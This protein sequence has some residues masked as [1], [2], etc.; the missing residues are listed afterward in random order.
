[1]RRNV[2]DFASDVRRYV[3]V[4]LLTIS[5]LDLCKVAALTYWYGLNQI[6]TVR[7]LFSSWKQAGGR[8][9]GEAIALTRETAESLETH[10]HLGH[11]SPDSFS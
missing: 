10:S 9:L 3:E 2:Y 8:S 7:Q 1:M 11:Q 5:E 4:C 6:E